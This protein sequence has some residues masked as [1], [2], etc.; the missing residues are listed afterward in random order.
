MLSGQVSDVAT[1]L[2][3]AAR[4]ATVEQLHTLML[5]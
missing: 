3:R 1:R 4:R 5:E 2:L